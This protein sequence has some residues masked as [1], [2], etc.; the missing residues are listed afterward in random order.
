MYDEVVSTLYKEA[1]D[2]F[3]AGLHILS[4]E[5]ITLLL[6]HLF[7]SFWNKKIGIILY[8]YLQET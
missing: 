8:M 1:N 5:Y 2:K 6:S 4:N 3:P 7:S